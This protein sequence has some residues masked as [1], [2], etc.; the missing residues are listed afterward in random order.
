VLVKEPGSCYLC[1]VSPAD[2]IPVSTKI[3]I[4]NSLASINT[5]MFFLMLLDAMVQI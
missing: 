4:T 2:G 1:H 5:N 3:E